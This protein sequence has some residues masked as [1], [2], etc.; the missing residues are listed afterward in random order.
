MGTRRAVVLLSLAV[1]VSACTR[2]TNLP[3]A[4]TPSSRPPGSAS[5]PSEWTSSGAGRDWRTY[6]GD[7]GSTHYSTLDQ[8]NT[9]NVTRL[10]VAWT[11]ETGDKGEFQTNNLIID[12]VL[13]TASP[14][15]KLMALDAGTGKEIWRFDPKS[16]RDD[17]VGNRQRGL[18][19]WESGDDRR[20]FTSAGT[21]L[22]AV[23]ARTGALIRS[24]GDNGSIHLGRG[25]GLGG[26]PTV[27]LNTP[28]VIY[29]DL[30]ILG[31]L[32]SEETAGAIRAFDVRTGEL[33]WVFRTIPRPGEYGYETWP[34]DAWKTAGGASDWSGHS[35]DEQRGIVYVS[36]E[37]A[38]PDFWG[39]D[40]FGAN[41][42]ANSVIA[43]DATTGKRLWHFQIVHHDLWDLDLPSPPTLLTVTHNGRR[44]DAVAQGTKHG[45]L[46]VFDR[47]TGSPLWPVRE[48]TGHESR[49]PGVKTWPT[50]PFP[51]K[52]APLMRQ[53]YTEADVSDISPEARVLTSERFKRAG[54]FGALPPPSLKETILFPG[55][56]GGFE[57]GG[58]AADPDGI[59]YANLNEIPWFYQMIPTRG[60]TGAPVSRGERQY[61]VHCASCHGMDRTGDAA[62]GMPPLL[63][64][65]DRLTREYVTKV[66]DSGGGR[67]PPFGQLP[68]T[69]RGAILDFLFGTER[70]AAVDAAA[71][72]ADGPAR[73][74]PPYAFAGFRRWFDREGYPAIKPPWGTLN[75]VD[76]NTGE[77]KWKVPLGEY[78]ELTK[79][80]IPPT[81]TENYGGPVVTA[82]G[83]IFIGA[84]ADE[85]FRAFDKATGQVLW[86]AKLPFSG[87]ATPSTYM[88][89]GKQYVVI[90]AGGGK[91]GRP[92]GGTIVAFAL[93]N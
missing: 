24:F 55:P 5:G 6:L 20:I 90:S 72:G 53:L 16:E 51:E 30:L 3:A 32:I 85:T 31:G 28:G 35:V 76:L 61:L 17:L 50:Q 54:S 42:F 68:E 44:I 41:L 4:S 45:L 69:Q 43:L 14:S 33:K 63:N 25:L 66:V 86:Q 65:R 87:N 37:T 93:P 1:L 64:M 36:T 78:P 38:G 23:N 22:Y 19:Y 91:S 49:I 60:P 75:A 59:L 82:G 67:M 15:R 18:A 88:V 92:A 70:P 39:G 27:R 7:K 74:G 34:P 26:T 62:G 48:R 9:G 52:P 58:A 57:W 21:W 79:R 13:Y 80:G 10:Q 83:L 81:G 84:T 8:I 73:E 89:N 12:G 71:P 77:I 46:F 2:S 29:K 56:D 47:V 11:F 40:R